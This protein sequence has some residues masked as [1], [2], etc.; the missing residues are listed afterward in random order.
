MRYCIGDVHGC[1]K[2]LKELIRQICLINKHPELYFVG[3]L[4]DRGPDSKAVIDYIIDLPNNGIQT[5]SVRGN[6]E[7]MLIHAYAH[8][9]KITDSKWHLNGAENTIRSFNA[10]ADLNKTIK[11]LIPEKYFRFLNSL[12]YFIELNDY[13]I[14]H[15]GFNFI[16]NN[17]FSDFE[18][19]L[20]TRKEQYNPEVTRGKKIIHGH[21]PI[22]LENLKRKLTTNTTDVINI[23]TGCV[24][25]HYKGLGYLTAIN[26]DTLKIISIKNID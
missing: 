8:N 15:A 12:P 3:D 17:P 20:W 9:Q 10:I 4:I 7:E 13:Y 26:P 22:A 18:T 2:T 14:V 5:K 25:T 16:L 21:S 24:Y 11:D 23:D 6:H 1:V 19:M